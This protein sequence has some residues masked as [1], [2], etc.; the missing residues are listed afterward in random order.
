M[1]IEERINRL[2]YEM[3]KENIDYYII[4]TSDYHNSEYISDFF[5]CREYMSGF[6]GSA[7]TLVVSG[8]ETILW[9]DGRYFIQAEEQL[10]NTGIKLYKSGNEGV[11]TIKEYLKKQC[12]NA[13]EITI[14]FDGKVMDLSFVK[15]LETELSELGGISIE[16]NPT[17]DLVGR[18]WTDRPQITAN[19]ITIFPEQ[20]AGKSAS[21]KLNE[22]RLALSEKNA[23]YHVLASL[24][25]IAW[26]L[27][28]RGSDIECNPV[29]LSYIFISEDDA[30]LFCHTDKVSSETKN[31]LSDIGIHLKEYDEIYDFLSSYKGEAYSADYVSET[32]D[33]KSQ[34]ETTDNGKAGKMLLDPESVNYRL[35][36]E[37]SK[38]FEI[39]EAFN[40]SLGLKGTKNETE[41]ENLREANV[42]DGVAMVKFLKWLDEY[43]NDASKATI[44][45][46]KAAEKLLE[47]R[48]E[49]A[50]FLGISF[51]TIAAYG[52][53][54]AIVHYEP[55]PETDI[56]VERKGFLLV[57]SGGQYLKGTTDI[58][59]TIAMGELTDDMKKCYTAVLKGNLRLSSAVFP[60]GLAGAN[61]D[62]L[63][64]GPLWQLEKDYNHGTGHGIGY[65]LNVHEGPQNINWKITQRYGN[66]V[67]FACGM[68]TSDEPGFYLAGEFGIRIENDILTVVKK[69]NDYGT[70][71]GFEVLTLAP[72]DLTP[73]ILE[74]L[75]REETE[76]L[77][78]YHNMVY[79][80]LSPY[81]DKE[82][83][84]WL[85]HAAV[86]PLC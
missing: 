49:S 69:E 23:E 6:T 40:P 36:T 81:L 72:I 15:A 26:L 4:P 50:E 5:K 2:L 31:Y 86:E 82:T 7:G 13:S 53:H 61:L 66:T 52:A 9:T 20:Y 71:L 68:V 77:K 25:D 11:P 16:I 83:A 51:E 63:A 38:H 46:L 80:K 55:T 62:I 58:T 8:L 29:F 56:L 30:I 47:F 33:K 74:D 67:P 32:A 19:E 21:E 12:E 65:Y 60:K 76:A 54:G 28:L 59:R 48:K 57:D 44:T 78:D 41:M 22:V 73:V 84:E 24:D 17:L 39:V 14:G 27:N 3:K 85:K 42:I 10:K 75:T 37:A 18:I 64:R 70:F 43:K 34:D 45:E 1:K 35:Y 79:D